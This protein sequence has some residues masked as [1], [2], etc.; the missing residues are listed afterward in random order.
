ME[1]MKRGS[2]P[3]KLLKRARDAGKQVYSRKDLLSLSGS[4]SNPDRAL[5]RLAKEGAI[6]KLDRGVWLVPSQRRPQFDVPRFWSNPDL[7]DP[8]TIS[9]LVVKNPTMRDVTRMVLAYGTRP[10]ELALCELESTLEISASVAAI[11][12]RMIDNAKRGL[13]RPEGG[14]THPEG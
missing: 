8:L 10:A 1:N 14:L 12:R 9:A 5:A 2:Q 4:I 3:F 11:S 6:E 7:Q 13:A